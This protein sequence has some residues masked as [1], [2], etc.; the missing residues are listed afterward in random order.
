MTP[1]PDEV[2]RIAAVEMPALRNLQI[3]E[4]YSRLAAA[5]VERE[6]QGA[7]W[8]T[9]ARSSSSRAPTWSG[10]SPASS[11]CRRR[12]MTAAPPFTPEQVERLRSG[13]LP[14]GVL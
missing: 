4:C 6:A 9:L 12:W 7:N 3:T 10:S 13:E 1:S 14:D 8:C 2:R 5:M 11:R